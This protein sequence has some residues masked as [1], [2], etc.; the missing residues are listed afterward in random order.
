MLKSRRQQSIGLIATDM[1]NPVVSLQIQALHDLFL[2]RGYDL[3]LGISQARADRELA[4]MRRMAE[5]RVAGLV[6]SWSEG[7]T[8]AACASYLREIVNQGMPVVFAGRRRDG[9]P[10]DSITVDNRAGT[11]AATD[12][13]LRTG[14]GKVAFIAGQRGLLAAETRCAG[15]R[16]ALAAAGL[17]ANEAWVLFGE[18]TRASGRVLTERLLAGSDRPDAVVCGND[19]M[20]IGALEA[21]ESCGFRVPADVAV[22][23]FDDI[24]LASLVRPRLTTVAQPLEKTADLI[25]KLLIER[26]EGRAPA[27]PRDVVLEPDLIVRESA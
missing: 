17:V 3:R 18:W 5:G 4:L 15:Y 12:Y 6:L 24:E 2:A 9:I 11:C 27:E 8:D 25:G 23:G 7:E 13:L 22:V 26:I 16:V 19:L 1:T 20:A 14:R 21:I 10:A